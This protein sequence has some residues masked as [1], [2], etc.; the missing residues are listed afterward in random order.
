[1]PPLAHVA[2]LCNVCLECVGIGIRAWGLRTFATKESFD[3]AKPDSL[4]SQ[5]ITFKTIRVALLPTA[6]R[7]H[8]LV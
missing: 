5:V 2:I 7:S 3:S 4:L 1:M 8:M 6:S